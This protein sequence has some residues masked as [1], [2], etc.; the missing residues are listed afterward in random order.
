MR[1]EITANSIDK[2]S[3]DVALI[4][5]FSQDKGEK[6]KPELLGQAEVI[7]KLLDGLLGKAV[8]LE[9]FTAKRGEMLSIVPGK[10]ILPSRVVVLGL[11]KKEEFTSDDLRR[12]AGKFSSKFK[13]SIDS[14][15]LAIPEELQTMVDLT[16][17]SQAIGEGLLLGSYEFAKYKAKKKY[18]REFASVIFS[19]AKKSDEKIIHDAIKK[20]EL[21]ANATIL[22]RDLVNE[23]PRIATPT[24]L[25]RFAQEIANKNLKNVRCT[26]IEK[27]QAEELGMDA[28]LSIASASSTPPKF[29]FL[30]Y[31][32]IK[33]IGKKKLALVG[34]GITFDSGGINVKTGDKMQTMKMDMAGAA[35]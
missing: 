6:S 4:F 26:I 29:I 12:A 33:P 1:F 3:S 10:K 24:Y 11:G 35:A 25:A 5:S 27:A 23:Q 18:E 8:E 2:I 20:A 16:T 30:E 13:K 31:N 9:M 14:V 28:F 34:K 15:S 32:P 22:A 7:D 21:Y 19:V 17:L